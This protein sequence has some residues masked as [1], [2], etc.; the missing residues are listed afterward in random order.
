M[1][2]D[3]R[4]FESFHAFDPFSMLLFALVIASMWFIFEKAKRPG[5]A[6]LIPVYNSVVMLEVA[7]KPWWWIFLLLI[8]LVNIVIGILAISSL[9][10]AFGK[11]GWFTV[12]L[13]FLPFIFLPI[14]GFGDAKYHKS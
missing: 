11:S 1:H 2:N 12:G 10:H 14:L 5:W 6:S 4:P 8:P 3:F 13:V 9:A 7:G